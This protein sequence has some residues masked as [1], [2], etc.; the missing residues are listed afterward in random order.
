MTTTYF[1]YL[2]TSPFGLKYL[3]KTTKDP[4]KYIGSG[5]IWKRHINKYKLTNEDIKTEILFETKDLEEFKKESVKISHKLDIVG[6]KEFANL[7]VEKGDGG[8]TSKHIDYSNPNFHR[9]NRADRL[10]GIG[11]SEEEKKKIFIERS[12]KINYRDPERL[13]KIKENTDWEKLV[14]NRN[15]DYSKFLNS[16]HERN[17]KPVLQFNLNGEFIMEHKSSADAVRF[18]NAKKSSS[19]TISNCCKDKGKTALGYKWKYKNK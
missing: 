8:D 7:I 3:G 2:K 17:K 15:T 11:L 6:S 4:Y 13:K 19:V 18:L 16:V 1:L 9:S 14:Q 12:K 5:K 10:N